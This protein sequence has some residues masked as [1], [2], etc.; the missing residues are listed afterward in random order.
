MGVITSR[1]TELDRRWL[2][3]VA[4]RQAP[5]W[6]DRS[7]RLVTH[8]GGAT[9]TIAVGLALTLPEATRSLGMALLFANLISHLVVQLVK[10]T[11]VRPRPFLEDGDPVALVEHPDAWSLPSGHS[12]AAMALA[13]TL[14]LWDGTGPLAAIALLGLAVAVGVSRVYLR[15]HYVT[16]VLAGQAIGIAGSIV[17]VSMFG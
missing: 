14:V 1:I 12:C 2:L 17:A 11:A 3:G 6:L 10:R 9:A 4:R 16:D 15:V 8:C 7:L 5:R 13:M